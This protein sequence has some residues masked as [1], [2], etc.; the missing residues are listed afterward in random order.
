MKPQELSDAM[1]FLDDSTLTETAN[2]L[3]KRPLR[4]RPFALVAAAACICIAVL[5]FVPTLTGQLPSATPGADSMSGTHGDSTPQGESTPSPASG[6]DSANNPGGE[7]TPPPVPGTASSTPPREDLDPAYVASV[8]NRGIPAHGAVD[9]ALPTIT[10]DAE[11]FVSGGMG[12]E[13]YMAYDISELENG[14][15]WRLGDEIGTL[16]VYRN[17]WWRNEFEVVENSDPDA[18]YARLYDIAALLGIDKSQ[19]TNWREEPPNESA[20]EAYQ[21]KYGLT[22]EEVPR[23][24]FNIYWIFAEAEGVR[25][26]IPSDLIATIEFDPTRPLPEGYD[27]SFDAARGDVETAGAYLLEQY[28]ALMGYETPAAAI[29]GGDRNIYGEQGYDLHMYEASEDPVRNLENYWLDFWH[30]IG[31]E[32]PGDL[33]LIRHWYCD[34]SEKLGDYPI[35]TP[36]EAWQMLQNGSSIT[37]VPFSMPED[38]FPARVD[39]V[40]RNESSAQVFMPYYRFLI[41]L[42]EMERDGL[43]DYGTWYVPAVQSEYLDVLPM[44]D[45]SFN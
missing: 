16:P 33:W 43:K 4:A 30:F 15:P 31:G 26:D 44:W 21:H 37:T 35:I 23:G 5:L 34:R 3:K 8:L 17:P 40:Y 19:L 27:L 45:G 12:Y 13:G 11:H 41:E 39:L 24:F 29:D 9:P 25:L 14:G 36:A 22:E 38:A 18:M 32:D 42:P 20:T 6:T 7:D 2:A 10:L 1:Q 28:R